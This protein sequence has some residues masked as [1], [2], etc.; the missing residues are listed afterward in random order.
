MRVA[1]KKDALTLGNITSLSL[2]LTL[3]PREREFERSNR[4]ERRRDHGVLR[5]CKTG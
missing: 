5:I 2:T 1:D 4:V 3:S